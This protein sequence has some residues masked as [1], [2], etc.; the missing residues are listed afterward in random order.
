[1]AEHYGVPADEQVSDVDWL[2]ECGRHGWAAL[3]ADA[4][5]RR[6]T[7]PE[8]VALVEARV[9]TFVINGQLTAEQ[10]VERVLANLPAIARACA[11]AGPFVYRVHLGQLQRL[12][13]PPTT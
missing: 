5:I 7:G 9:Q 6:R 10:K 2:H 13:I 3:K 11:V 1:L 4:N 12:T 8:R